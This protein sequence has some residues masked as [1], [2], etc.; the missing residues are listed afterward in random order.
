MV[1]PGNWAKVTGQAGKLNGPIVQ[2]GT[3]GSTDCRPEGIVGEGF[4][5]KLRIYIYLNKAHLLHSAHRLTRDPSTNSETHPSVQTVSLF[6]S[7]DNFSK[8]HTM[9]RDSRRDRGQWRGCHNFKGIVCDGDRPGSSRRNGGLKMGQ[10][11]YFYVRGW[12]AGRP[13]TSRDPSDI[14]LLVNP[15]LTIDIV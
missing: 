5:P 4:R 11:Y 6:G 2:L 8:Q 12:L 15:S 3:L 1:A 14:P 7:W 9:E 13:G 10:P